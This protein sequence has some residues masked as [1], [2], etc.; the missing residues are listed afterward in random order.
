MDL[1]KKLFEVDPPQ[2]WQQHV[3]GTRHGDSTG[4]WFVGD[5]DGMYPLGAETP[6]AVL[7]D[8]LL[9]FVPAAAR[10]LHAFLCLSHISH[11]PLVPCMSCTCFKVFSPRHVCVCVIGAVSS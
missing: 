5:T 4:P 6:A 2:L 1:G 7:F 11:G 8:L 10:C 9:V 3:R